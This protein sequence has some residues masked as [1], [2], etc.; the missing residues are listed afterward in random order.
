[1]SRGMGRVPDK[2]GDPGRPRGKTSTL[3][4]AV[5]VLLLVPQGAPRA[6]EG[7][8]TV[9]TGS[10][11]PSAAS[12][13]LAAAGDIAN[14]PG[15]SSRAHEATS[16]LVVSI[17]PDVVLAL[18]DSQH[19]T[20]SLAEYMGQGAYDDT[21]GRFKAKTRP[22]PGNKDYLTSGAKGYFDYFNG[23]GDTGLAGERGKGYYSYDVGAWHV[24][25]LNSE[26]DGSAGSPQEQWLRADLA[27]NPRTCILAYSHRPL[28]SSQNPAKSMADLGQVLYEGDADVILSGHVHTYERLAPQ[29]PDGKRDPNGMRQFIVG[30]GGH[31]FHSSDGSD[32]NSE[33]D[34]NATHG[35]LKMTLHPDSYDWTFVPV[36]GKTFTD[37]GSTRCSSASAPGGPAD[38]STSAPSPTAR[39]PERDGAA[40]TEGEHYWL[41]ASDGGIFA[42][43]DAA[44][45]GSTG[46]IKLAQPIVGMVGA[47]T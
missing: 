19:N 30:T 25:A 5:V 29:T 15:S 1:M 12:P 14:P 38:P 4:V 37:S 47:R 21:W 27:A 16:D 40:A 7:L 45:L 31:P 35:V 41:V 46:A 43:G 42:F 22:V 18:G 2:G 11:R 24:V 23:G 3:A 9:A 13:V 34:H 32:P 39:S 6:E 10:I 44:F 33:V 28:F 8:A 20:G 36:A 17:N 26:I